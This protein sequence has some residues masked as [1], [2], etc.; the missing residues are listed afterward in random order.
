MGTRQT[1]LR[2]FAISILTAS[3]MFTAAL[4]FAKGQGR[5]ANKQD[6]DDGPY[7][8]EQERRAINE[9]YADH[10][11]SLPPG[12]AKRDRL[13]P[14]LEK[15]LVRRGT[16]PPGLQKKIQPCPADLARRLPPPP[17]D[18]EH[19]ILSGHIV[20]LHRATFNIL[21]VVHIEIR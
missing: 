6:D 20:L 3:L 8:G 15:Q 5:N 1:K 21:D 19:V 7:Y 18:Y 14:G 9:W 12:L 4:T 10:A 17:P 11:S 13:P 16:L 2:L